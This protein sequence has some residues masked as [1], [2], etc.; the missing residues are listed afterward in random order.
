MKKRTALRA[1]A[2][3]LIMALTLSL[4]VW[5][6]DESNADR[7]HDLGLFR[8]TGSGYALDKT[9]TRMQGLIMLIRLLGEEE[10]ALSFTDPC[11]FTDVASGDPSRYAAYA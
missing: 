1:I 8:G 3:A 6:L 10:E 7:L 4:N 9:A 5:A 11:P 2:M